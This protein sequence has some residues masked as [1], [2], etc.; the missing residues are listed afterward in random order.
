MRVV[1][2]V[3]VLVSAVPLLVLAVLGDPV[4][5]PPVHS[6]S[7]AGTSSSADSGPHWP[8]A[9]L[10]GTAAAHAHATRDVKVYDG[11]APAPAWRT[12]VVDTAPSP[13]V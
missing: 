11:P 1:A 3:V 10:Q 4:V 7:W 6:A 8:Y 2:R 12:F 5:R 13:R 9:A